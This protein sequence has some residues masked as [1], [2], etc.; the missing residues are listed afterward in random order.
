MNIAILAST[1]GSI[2]P[3]IF[4]QLQSSLDL[5]PSLL[6]SNIADCGALK[7][8]E[9]KNIKTIA[10]LSEGKMREE[11]DTEAIRI[12][13]E[14]SIDLILLVGFMRILSPIFVNAFPKKILNI[15]PS[16]LP[17]FAGGMD[18]EVH[19]AVIDAREKESGATIHF[20]DESVDGGEI[21][22]QKKVPIASR[23]TAE[24]LKKKV[25]ALEGK[26]FVEAVKKYHTIFPSR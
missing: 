9:A 21:F 26:M 15:H 14:H 12:L 22:L 17:K 16:L 6:L 13:Q 5:R 10:L 23:E 24:S 3:V 20:V 7:K 25:Q 1:N 4:E 18:L 2:L 8:A 11:W 19:Q